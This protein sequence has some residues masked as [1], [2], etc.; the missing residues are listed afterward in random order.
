[1]KI[2]LPILFVLLFSQCNTFWNG[3]FM[4][5][6]DSLPNF[7]IQLVDSSVISIRGGIKEGK[8]VILLVFDPDCGFCQS[9][10][11]SIINDS[12]IMVRTNVVMLTMVSYD[13][14]LSFHNSFALYKFPNVLLARDIDHFSVMHFKLSSVPFNAI[15]DRE[16]LLS[17]KIYGRIEAKDLTRIIMTF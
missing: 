4:S 14:M 10:I 6:R 8:P 15:Y 13:Q 12:A 17:A 11:K 2:Y 9:E 5:S 16:L 1:M 7:S 3:E